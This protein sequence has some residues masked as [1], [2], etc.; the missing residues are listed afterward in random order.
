MKNTTHPPFFVLPLVRAFP[1]LYSPKPE[2]A[3]LPP[4]LERK[5]NYEYVKKSKYGVC[6]SVF[7]E[8]WRTGTCALLRD[9]AIVIP[10]RG[11]AK[12]KPDEQD[13]KKREQEN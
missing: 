9:D 7:D 4:L 5:A 8:L 3:K 10:I 13:K 2:A 6:A 11:D 12:K 1:S